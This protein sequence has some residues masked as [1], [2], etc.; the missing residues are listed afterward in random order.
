[1]KAAADDGEAG[2]GAAEAA[3]ADVPPPDYPVLRF[4]ATEAQFQKYGQSPRGVI[5]WFSPVSKELVVFL[6]GDERLGKGAT[7]AVVYHE[8]WHQFADSYFGS[9]GSKQRDPLH[10]WFDEGHGDY[11]GSFDLA[12]GRWHYQGSAMRGRTIE[13]LQKTGRVPSLEELVHWPRERFYGP[14]ASQNY[15]VAYALVDF[16]RRGDR[17]RKH[18]KPIYASVLDDY[19]NVM[20]VFGDSQRATDVAFR[21]FT[22]EDWRDL[23]QAWNEWVTSSYFKDG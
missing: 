19:K 2:D 13:Y 1:V 11:F 22:A 15:A 10:R 3:A 16:L 20:L 7:E 21:E 4:C 14:T 5:G 23:Q 12:R 18:W 6:G 9:A 17:L 8:G